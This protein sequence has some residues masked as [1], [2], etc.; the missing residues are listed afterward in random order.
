[1]IPRLPIL[2]LLSVPVRGAQISFSSV[3]SSWDQGAPYDIGQT[4]NGSISDGFGWGVFNGQ[5]A[6]QT[7][8]FTAAAPVTTN[9]IGFAL[10]WYFGGNHYGQSFRLSWTS[11]AAPS[12]GGNWTQITPAVSAPRWAEL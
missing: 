12:A 10:P 9:E 8:V 3:T 5:N 1:M 2:L 7:A 11:D 4:I 6:P